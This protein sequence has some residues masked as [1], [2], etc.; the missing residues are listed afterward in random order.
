VPKPTVRKNSP[1]QVQVTIAPI[2]GT[3][4]SNVCPGITKGSADCTAAE[5]AAAALG[6]T[7]VGP[8]AAFEKKPLTKEASPED[9]VVSISLLE[10]G[11]CAKRSI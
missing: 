11:L 4:E 2:G 7:F 5:A 6:S 10:T 9:S 8:E 3:R 1:A